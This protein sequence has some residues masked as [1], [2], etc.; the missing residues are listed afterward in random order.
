[1]QVIG[2]PGRLS[3]S[4]ASYRLA[5]PR[6]GQDTRAVLEAEL[7]LGG[8]EIEALRTAGVVALGETTRRDPGAERTP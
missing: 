2:F 4:P 7:G 3:R 1:V 5:P 6:L 8:A